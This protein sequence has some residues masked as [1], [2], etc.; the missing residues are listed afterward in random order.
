MSHRNEVLSSAG[1]KYMR[2]YVYGECSKHGVRV[3]AQNDA[4]MYVFLH[5]VCMLSACLYACIQK[6]MHVDM[7]VVMRS[8]V[9][10]SVLVCSS[11]ARVPAGFEG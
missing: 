9:H 10:T 7:L 4:C 2:M 3:R 8:S 5:V 6:N 11:F 1:L